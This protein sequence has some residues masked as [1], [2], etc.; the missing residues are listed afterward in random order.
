LFE[1][2]VFDELEPVLEE[3]ELELDEDVE[4]ELGPPTPVPGSE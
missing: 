3:P 2:A 1:F 4:L